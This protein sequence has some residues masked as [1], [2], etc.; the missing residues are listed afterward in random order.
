MRFEKEDKARTYFIIDDDANLLAYFTLSFK[1]VVLHED[2]KN[3]HKRKLK[4]NNNTVSAHL[5]GQ[6]G[7]NESIQNNPLNLSLIL[8]DVYSIINQAKALI[9][10]RAI[11]LECE[12]TKK[13]IKLYND[14]GFK[15]L[16]I[17][18]EDQELVTM[19]T[20]IK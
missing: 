10:G 5:I 1:D 6:I 8:N 20:I 13:L 16:K 4:V 17:A 19:F 12:N 9:G 15:E 11:I 7:K 3:G 2:A 18:N 14:H